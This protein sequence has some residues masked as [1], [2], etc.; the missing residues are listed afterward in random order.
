MEQAICTKVH[1]H[2]LNFKTDIKNW[3][4]TNNVKTFQ[5]ER[6]VTSAFIE[7]ITAY[8]HVELTS[9]DFQKRKRVCKINQ[10]ERC[11]AKRANNEQCSRRRKGGTCFCGTHSKG[12]PHGISVITD[13]TSAAEKKI[14]IW[15]ED[16]L[17]IIYYLD[18]NGNIY[19]PEDI[20][21]DV[22]PPRVIGSWQRNEQNEI[23]ITIS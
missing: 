20:V 5:E 1:D 7:F 9:D 4:E 19:S 21:G 11:I 18:D 22:M 10:N 14:E 2:C 15:T 13:E 23:K 3:L 16:V 8:K 17:G 12:T 6:D